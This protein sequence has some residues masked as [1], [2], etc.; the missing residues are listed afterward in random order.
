M[1]QERI[2]LLMKAQ[3]MTPT[4]FADEIGIQRSSISHILSG[5]N[6]PSLDVI[7]KILGRFKEIDS[8]WLILGKGNLLKER[9]LDNS[10]TLFNL[11]EDEEII[12]K[13]LKEINLK[14]E[15]KEKEIKTNNIEIQENIIAIQNTNSQRSISKIIILY[16]D[17]SYEELVKN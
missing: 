10:P 11:D 4:Q 1:I 16:N 3:G 15:E 2:L 8:N 17:N 7:L 12:D 6:N 13:N 14:E 5:R 9:D